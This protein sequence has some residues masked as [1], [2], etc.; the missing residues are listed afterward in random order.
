VKDVKGLIGRHGGG[1][2]GGSAAGGG[3][4]AAQRSHRQQPEQVWD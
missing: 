4:Q 2:R 3:P 1:L